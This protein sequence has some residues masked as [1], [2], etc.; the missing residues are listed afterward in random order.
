MLKAPRRSLTSPLCSPQTDLNIGAVNNNFDYAT[1]NGSR[2]I[3]VWSSTDAVN[4]S[5]DNLVQVMPD[6]TNAGM[7]WA[8]SAQWDPDT[9][10]YAVFWSSRVY[11]ADDTQRTGTGSNDMIYYSHTTDF[12]NFDTPQIWIQEDYSVID[13]ELLELSASSFVRFIKDET[14][15]KVYSERSDN[16]LFGTW[17]RIDPN[18]YIIDAVREGPAAYKDINKSYRTWLWLDNYSGQGS[19]EAY[20]NDDITQNVW[21]ASDPSLTPTGMRHGTVQQVTQSTL[22]AL[23][24]KYPS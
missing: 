12:V 5:A 24:A 3:H 14:A 21:T 6:S 13:Q 17:T 20:Y 18:N 4:W 16:G 10:S 11:A 23:N 1:R 9:S 15:T 8:P 22:D 7:V 2:S 19:Y